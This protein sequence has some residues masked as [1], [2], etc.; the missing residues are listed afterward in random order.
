M[1]DTGAKYAATVSQGTGGISWAVLSVAALGGSGTPATVTANTFDANAISNTAILSNFSM[2]VPGGATINGILV[3]V[4]RATITTGNVHDSVVRLTKSAGTGTGD[5]KA[6]TGTNYPISGG[7]ASVTY[8]GSTD[9]WGTTWTAA[10]VNGTG[11]GLLFSMESES[12]NQDAGVD[13]I[14][15]TVYY[16]VMS[17]VVADGAH[18]HTAQA[19]NVAPSHWL[20]WDKFDRANGAIGTSDSGDTWTNTGDHVIQVNTNRAAVTA[21][22][23]GTNYTYL[24]AGERP[25]T[26]Q[27]DVLAHTAIGL[28]AGVIYR[29]VDSNDFWMVLLYYNGGTDWRVYNYLCTAGT[30]SRE[31]YALVTCTA[32]NY[33][34]LKITDDGTNIAISFDGT[35]RIT[36]SSTAQNAGTYVGLRG[37][38]TSAR[39]DN[40]VA[41]GA[42]TAVLAVADATHA[43]TAETPTLTQAHALTVAAAAHAHT[44]QAPVLAQAHTLVVA[45]AA[46]AHTAAAP[47]LAQSYRLA[48]AD[49]SHVHAA[50][51]PVLTQAHTLAV[52]DTSHAHT[53]GTALLLQAHALL[54]AD[55]AHAQAAESPVLAQS[56]RLAV[57]DA[58]YGHSAGAVTLSQGHL[59]AV[60]DAA[61]VHTAGAPVLG[62]VPDLA[63]VV[64]ADAARYGAALTDA[65]AYGLAVTNA[66]VYTLTL[67]DALV[68]GAATTDALVTALTLEETIG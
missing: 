33:Y 28:S 17:L 61:H 18:T 5:N 47:V 48:V 4:N 13:Y 68:Y 43:H 38:T 39:Y 64:L 41:M 16:T 55:A 51:A 25:A 3:T 15:I 56:I 8:G 27:V 62:T 7:Y 6:A 31:Q 58:T 24:D 37:N 44:T 36:D 9:L 23:T 19:A 30:Y 12:A 52:A 57:A 11:F 53:A 65:S 32:N 46:H 45:N 10:E 54:V 63:T 34:T 59:L 2:G 50:D 67:S 14:S 20:V 42:E 49:A 21:I 40:F 1:A 26:I 60:A 29:G 22:G 35:Q 66:S